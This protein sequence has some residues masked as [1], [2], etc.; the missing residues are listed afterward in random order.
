MLLATIFL[1]KLLRCYKPNE[2]LEKCKSYNIKE[3]DCMG[4][5]YYPEK[6]YDDYVKSFDMPIHKEKECGNKKCYV[7]VYKDPPRVSISPDYC[8]CNANGNNENCK[9]YCNK[10]ATTNQTQ[11]YQEPKQA[12]S[13]GQNNN[14]IYNQSQQSNAVQQTPQNYQQPQIYPQYVYTSPQVYNPPQNNQNCSLECKVS[15]EQNSESEKNNNICTM[16]PCSIN[17]NINQENIPAFTSIDNLPSQDQKCYNEQCINQK[18]KDSDVITLTRVISETKT[19]EKPLTL[20]REVTTTVISEHPII[21]YKV[22]TLTEHSTSTKFK[23]TTETVTETKTVST[24]SLITTTI[25]NYK[26]S[27]IE[28]ISTIVSESTAFSTVTITET[29]S[30]TLISSILSTIVST[31]IS[32]SVSTDVS[33]KIATESYIQTSADKPATTA[34]VKTEKPEE[35]ILV[36]EFL[37]LL[38]KL[39][40]TKEV[41]SNC[42]IPTPVPEISCIEPKTSKT[43]S[44]SISIIKETQTEKLTCK[45]KEPIINNTITTTEKITCPETKAE[46]PTES[47]ITETVTETEK[48]ICPESKSISPVISKIKETVTEK[49]TC[50]E[51]KSESPLVST[52]KQT[53]T[54][55]ETETI[56]KTKKGKPEISRESIT[57]TKIKRKTVT[58]TETEKE[59]TS[60]VCSSKAHRTVFNT[61]Y[62]Y[63]Y[64]EPNSHSCNTG[65]CDKTVTETVLVCKEN[66]TAT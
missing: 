47:L 10:H 13:Q 57:T 34:E 22:T 24:E 46:K 66:Y 33:T 26:T 61:I 53:V 14:Q 29:S 28:S 55:T 4:S 32:T 41:S 54:E 11:Q 17:L 40:F 19:I 37:P 23:E 12:Y 2:L 9:L 5:I 62:K 7:V 49:L 59:G 51:T 38:Q 21:N 36:K 3:E 60:S 27:T 6:K 58:V 45:E 16:N 35:N 20:Y 48:I 39:F 43:F 18:E 63:G 44:S 65:I 31:E 56:T 15:T 52:I 8:N 50:T 25:E 42:I 64:S 1:P 30:T